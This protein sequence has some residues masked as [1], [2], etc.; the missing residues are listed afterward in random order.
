MDGEEVGGQELFLPVTALRVDVVNYA[1]ATESMVVCS[2][3][4]CDCFVSSLRSRCGGW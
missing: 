1:G 4:S 3:R 2:V